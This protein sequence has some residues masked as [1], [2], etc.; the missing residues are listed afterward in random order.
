M[1]VS[2]SHVIPFP[3]VKQETEE[4]HFDHL[5]SLEEDVLQKMKTAELRSLLGDIETAY[6]FVSSKTD[7]K[8]ESAEWSEDTERMELLDDLADIVLDI[9]DSRGE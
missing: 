7:A 4:D 1:S 5:F 8:L 6:T 3:K 9:L 2:D